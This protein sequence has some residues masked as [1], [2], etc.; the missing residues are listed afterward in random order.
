MGNLD[1]R[2]MLHATPESIS[3]S[4][5]TMKETYHNLENWILL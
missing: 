1:P 3:A 5:Q 2:L 4:M